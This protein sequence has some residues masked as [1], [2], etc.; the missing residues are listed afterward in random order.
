VPDS[1]VV[2][3]T[4]PAR[5]IGAELARVLAAKG[6]RVSLVGLEP[7]RLAALSAELG[8]GH[9]WF[10]CDVTDQAALDRAVAGTLEAFGGIDVVVANAGI[11]SL[12]TLR[13][14]P[15]EAL[16]R[17]VDVNLTGVVRTVRATVDAVVAREGYY[18]LV[19]SLA[20]LAPMPGL[21]VYAAAKS[22]VEQ[23]ANAL[24]I[25]L[26][27]DGVQ[28]GSAHPA[29]I[30]TDLVRDARADLGVFRDLMNRLPGRLGHTTSVRDCA[31]ALADAIAR[32]RRRV[33]VPRGIVVAALLRPLL[34]SRLAER[35][36]ARR[37]A[38]LIPAFDD[39]VRALGRSFGAT[40]VETARPASTKD[41][42][43]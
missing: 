27:P 24:R 18:L 21:A 11:A 20:A 9:R 25:E 30:E 29:W 15:P 3:I 40:S 42:A 13:A 28:V 39:E 10:E 14:T 8:P 34:T 16:A 2:L 4:G 23:L 26:G 32:R 1:A 5:G 35:V 43:R 19:S 36:A 31:D 33:Y 22:G 7:E 37:L 38:P 12:G 6:A 41:R 17:V